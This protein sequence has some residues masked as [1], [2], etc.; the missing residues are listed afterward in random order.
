MSR[1]KI[2]LLSPADCLPWYILIAFLLLSIASFGVYF[3]QRMI[4]EKEHEQN[5][6]V[7]QNIAAKQVA[8]V[9]N[10]LESQFS[11]LEIFAQVLAKNHTE[12]ELIPHINTVAK[13][14]EF[15]HIFI[16]DAQGNARSNTNAT[17]NVAD[18]SYFQESMLGR[19]SI[20]RISS[21][22]IGGEPRFILSVPIR[23]DGAIVGV[24]YGSY[25]EQLFKKLIADNPTG[26]SGYTFIV[27]REGNV[28]IES[29]SPSYLLKEPRLFEEMEMAG[30]PTETLRSD[31][32]CGK[33]GVISYAFGGRQRYASYRPI[34]ANEWMLF[35]VV[36]AETVDAE[37]EAI[38]QNGWFLFGLIA[39]V[40]LFF[41]GIILFLAR[42]SMLRMVDE[43]AR[44]KLNA[45]RT[46]IAIESTSISIWDYDLKTRSIIQTPSSIARHGFQPVIPDVPESLIR[47]GF[48]HPDS[49]ADFL[50]LYA[51][52]FAGKPKT[53][54]VFLVRTP[55]REGWW[56]EHIR[57]T[58]LFDESGKPYRAI[59]VSDDVT[60][61][62]RARQSYERELVFQRVMEKNVI[63]TALVNVS[64]QTLERIRYNREYAVEKSET[65]LQEFS[66][67]SADRVVN[68]PEVRDFF[69]NLTPE[70]LE[71]RFRQ[72]E[73]IIEFEYARHMSGQ[74]SRFVRTS[75]HLVLEPV[76]KDLMAFFT[77][78]DI[79]AERSKIR[80]LS[81]AAERDS[82][83]MLYNHQTTFH[84][85]EQIFSE[86]PEAGHA[87][88]MID[89]D[90]FKLVNDIFGH[91]TG[92][93]VIHFFAAQLRRL[94]R[95]SDILGRIG[96]DEFLVLM[97]NTKQAAVNKKCEEL[98]SQLQYVCS[99]TDVTLS[100]SASIGV[101]VC[102][103]K[104][105]LADIYDKADKAL[106]TV[107]NQG[108]Q[109]YCI[110][111]EAD[112]A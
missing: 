103:G 35:N 69:L 16:V 15:L 20:A 75:C 17:T 10:K 25:S 12:E 108:K 74:D 63:R 40:S 83:T 107:K 22:R 9:Q 50:A 82:M 53:E 70:V 100:V 45:E 31:L 72:G 37:S 38:I 91:Q 105:A 95:S 99:K 27:D 36:P 54:G 96:G 62:C 44:E 56:Y 2:R 112:P 30:N 106:Y 109:D 78:R 14:S 23:K 77:M 3:H 8:L 68:D 73:K 43:Q 39:A 5:F 59:G 61:E 111:T 94:F 57:Y 110:T 13:A 104:H 102:S 19:R 1:K 79:E 71:P 86:D 29:D 51:E 41:F 66:R 55:D 101:Y 33:P 18:R 26:D 24:L 6:H 21:G 49:H 7:L 88:F 65:T 92:D 85:I 87:L 60:A 67:R 84:K 64:M 90:N 28:I 58:N 42:R 93:E 47:C 89:I 32:A 48:V 97:R 98:V 46:R 80:A 11:L 76:S 52:L 81:C 4:I 34:P